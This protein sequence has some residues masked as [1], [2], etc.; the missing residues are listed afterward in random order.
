MTGPQEQ[1][2]RWYGFEAG[3]QTREMEEV[4]NRSGLVRTRTRARVIG[5]LYWFAD[6]SER[7]EWSWQRTRRPRLIVSTRTMPLGWIAGDAVPYG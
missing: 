1:G 4:P 3:G 7:D 5:V 6:E 2:R